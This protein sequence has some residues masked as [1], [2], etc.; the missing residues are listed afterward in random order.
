MKASVTLEAVWVI[1]LVL[2][3]LFFLLHATIHLF[4]QTKEIAQISWFMAQDAPETFLEQYYIEEGF[5]ILED[6]WK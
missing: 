1:S 4:E 2:C 6:L 3:V 5:E